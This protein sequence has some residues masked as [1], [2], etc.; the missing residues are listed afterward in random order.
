MRPLFNRTSLWAYPLYAAVGGSFGFWLQGVDQRQ[1]NLISERKE[2]LL[3]KRR[4]R[5]EQEG[6]EQAA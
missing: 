1:M 6:V 3:E 5:D 4:R 2:R